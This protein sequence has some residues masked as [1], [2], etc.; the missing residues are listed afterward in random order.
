MK[1]RRAK[2]YDKLWKALFKKTKDYNLIL[3]PECFMID[4]E[5]VMKSSFQK[6]FP[7]CLIRGC[8]W[9]FGCAIFKEIN[10]N[11]YTGLLSYFFKHMLIKLNSGKSQVSTLQSLFLTPSPIKIQK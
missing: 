6:H 3:K 9:H 5:I 4:F 7:D 1:I 11:I 2:D 10:L 8:I